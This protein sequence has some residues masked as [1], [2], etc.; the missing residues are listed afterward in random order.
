[1]PKKE[2]PREREQRTKNA[3]GSAVWQEPFEE[4]RAPLVANLRSDPFERAEVSE[5]M[6]Y[7]H[8]FLDH[9]FVIAP[10]AVDVAQWLQSFSEF[11]P[12]HHGEARYAIEAPRA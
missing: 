10:A 7:G 6:D 4:L 2:T 11:P 1:M 3:R 9:V 5:G 8:W 12:R